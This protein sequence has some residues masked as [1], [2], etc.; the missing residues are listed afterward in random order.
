[1]KSRSEGTSVSAEWQQGDCDHWKSKKVWST[2][3]E[4]VFSR[5]RA[6]TRSSD[7]RFRRTLLSAQH[8]RRLGT[9][10]L[11]SSLQEGQPQNYRHR[12]VA[13]E[14]LEFLESKKTIEKMRIR[15][16]TNTKKQLCAK[17]QSNSLRSW[18]GKQ[19]HTEHTMEKVE[20]AFV[21]VRQ[22]FAQSDPQRR[23]GHRAAGSGER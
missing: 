19:A 14:E 8:N 21:K 4:F 22:H 23:R 16:K 2:P 13:V 17:E 9:I 1:M 12:R 3:R 11:M 20:E 6:D 18:G 10:F 15:E 5:V 7:I